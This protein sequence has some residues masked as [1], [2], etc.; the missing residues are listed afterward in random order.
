MGMLVSIL[1]LLVVGNKGSINAKFLARS[2]VVAA[3]S[4]FVLYFVLG[5]AFEKLGVDG[6]SFITEKFES[7]SS[8]YH[9]DARYELL[10]GYLSGLSIGSFIT[11]VDISKIPIFALLDNT[12]NSFLY[13]HYHYG[14]VAVA[15]IILLIKTL[16]ILF[17]KDRFLFFVLGLLILRGMTDDVFF[18]R[19]YDVVILMYMLTPY[20]SPLFGKDNDRKR[21]NG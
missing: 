6:F 8:S 2:I 15:I 19:H 10:S 11:G 9:E 18:V 21:I 4:F 1:M 12:H 5:F 13:M 17:Y 20:Y 7:H 14:I 3:V 16:I